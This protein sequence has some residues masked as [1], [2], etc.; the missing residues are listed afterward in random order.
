M[1]RD[2]MSGTAAVPDDNVSIVPESVDESGVR[3]LRD[4]CFDAV[5]V[6]K[7]GSQMGIGRRR[8]NRRERENVR[9]I[10]IRSSGSSCSQQGEQN[11][12][13]CRKKEIGERGQQRY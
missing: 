12:E 5:A 4:R 11:G 13:C 6:A 10:V 1:I 8:S 9:N 2:Q 3:V 7:A